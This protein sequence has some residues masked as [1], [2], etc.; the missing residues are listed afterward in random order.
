VPPASSTH[1]RGRLLMLALADDL[2]V[3]R[4]GR[5]TEVLL[6]LTLE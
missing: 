5:G 3:C 2:E 6:G 4:A 1:G